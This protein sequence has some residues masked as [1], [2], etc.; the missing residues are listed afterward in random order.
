MYKC[1]YII[2]LTN[3]LLNREKPCVWTRR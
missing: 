1:L 3:Y 2:I